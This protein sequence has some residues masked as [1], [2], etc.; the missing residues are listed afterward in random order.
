MSLARLIESHWYAPRRWLLCLLAP[1][2]GLFVVLSALRRLLYRMGVLRVGHVPVP[3]VVVGNINV[4]GVGKTPLTRYL[5]SELQVRG[6]QVGLISRG[7]G[8]RHRQPTPVLPDSDPAEVGDEPLLLVRAGCPLW[9]G[10]DRVATARA[11]LAAHPEVDVILSDD[12]LQHYRL[13]RDVEIA[14]LDAARGLGNGWRL[15]A[16]P[17][18][19]GPRRLASVN[20]V[21]LNGEG[22]L[23][24]GLPDHVPV[25]RMRLQPGMFWQL[26][27]PAEQRAAEEF[28]ELD[29]VALAGIG[30]P[31][32]FFDTVRQLGIPLRQT[33]AFPDH[34]AFVPTDVPV[35][36]AVLVTEKD[37][38][39]LVACNNVTLWALP[40]SAGLEPDLADWL[41]HTL[42]GLPH[43]RQAA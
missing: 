24:A 16:G 17:L 29:C 10:R 6:W 11:L 36:G 31:E 38:V 13:G 18:R 28:K 2:S 15:P 1:L 27:A 14:V 8:G 26:S 32:R 5:V 39:K 40:V 41:V 23:P 33:L 7:Y 3:V 20:A 21:V 25:F 43:G 9:V 30:H 34:H 19:E 35:A 37:A 4:G 22:S 42:E 12:G